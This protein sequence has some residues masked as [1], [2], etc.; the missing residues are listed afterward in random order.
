M[1]VLVLK[2]MRMC[3]TV[4]CALLCVFLLAGCGSRSSVPSAH[5]EEVLSTL[6]ASAKL[7][8]TASYL[9]CFTPA[10]QSAY[11]SSG[12]YDPDLTEKLEHSEDGKEYLLTY[13]VL[14]HKE[15]DSAG[16]ASLKLDYTEKYSQRIEI[17]KAYD[18]KIEFSSGSRCVTDK[19]TVLYNGSQWLI[20][21]DVIE[22]FFK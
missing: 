1:S 5:Y 7:N 3:K 10:A 15:L 22:S 16:I 13:T 6:T 17:V 8:D 19:V 12:R 20:L 9:K 11:L 18:L 4:I 21:G 14:D 2:L